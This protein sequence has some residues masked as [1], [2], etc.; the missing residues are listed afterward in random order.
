MNNLYLDGERKTGIDKKAYRDPLENQFDQQAVT[1]VTADITEK[2]NQLKFVRDLYSYLY[3][4]IE[5]GEW[6]LGRK[7]KTESEH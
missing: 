4:L 7:D 3:L 2:V 6:D 5:I 1:T